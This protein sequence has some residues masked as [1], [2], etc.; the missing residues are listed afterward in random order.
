MWRLTIGI[1]YGHRSALTLG[2]PWHV[3]VVAMVMGK[4]EHGSGMTR[5][6]NGLKVTAYENTK[7]DDEE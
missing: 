5:V 6:E 4:V 2:L 7:T 3:D 1:L